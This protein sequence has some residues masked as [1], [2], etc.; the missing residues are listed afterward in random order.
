[1]ACNLPGELRPLVATVTLG[2]VHSLIFSCLTVA[3]AKLLHAD[4]YVFEKIMQPFL[5]ICNLNDDGFL[6]V[7]VV[8]SKKVCARSR[9][10][11][12]SRKTRAREPLAIYL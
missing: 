6:G 10:G 4:V 3:K 8:A 12:C 9:A 2:E 7:F 1:M 11:C 5:K